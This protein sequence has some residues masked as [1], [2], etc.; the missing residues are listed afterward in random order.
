MTLS[1]PRPSHGS[2]T[3]TQCTFLEQLRGFTAVLG[4]WVNTLPAPVG[5]G[6]QNQTPAGSDNRGLPSHS[7][8][9]WKP[10]VRACQGLVSG[11]DSLLG[12]QT[13]SFPLCPR[14]ERPFRHNLLSSFETLM[15]PYAKVFCQDTDR[16]FCRVPCTPPPPAECLLW[17]SPWEHGFLCPVRFRLQSQNEW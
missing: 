2:L 15:I 4:L 7:F 13:A 9:G 11:E 3:W 10:Q 17:A 14:A 16:G 1:I 6:C 12:L 5:F 8:G